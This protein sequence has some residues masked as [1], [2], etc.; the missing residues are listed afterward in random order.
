[1]DAC[2]AFLHQKYVLMGSTAFNTAA[3]A[4]AGRVDALSISGVSTASLLAGFG[5]E[6]E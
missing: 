6:S 2:L 1:M 3:L 4:S 5:D